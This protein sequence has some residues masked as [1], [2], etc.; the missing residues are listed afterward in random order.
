MSG[1]T[2]RLSNPQGVFTITKL[3]RLLFHSLFVCK[4][5]YKSVVQLRPYAF[6]CPLSTQ[7]PTDKFER[8]SQS[9]VSMYSQT[10]M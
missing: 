4:R 8:V 3:L 7:I 9:F 5:K 10:P 6:I 2:T 1:N